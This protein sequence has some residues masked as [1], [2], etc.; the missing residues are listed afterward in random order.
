LFD[1]EERYA[2]DDHFS[3]EDNYYEKSST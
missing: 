1:D 2:D 3:Q